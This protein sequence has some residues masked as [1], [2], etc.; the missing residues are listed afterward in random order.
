M[1]NFCKPL[2][3]SQPAPLSMGFSRQESW[4]GLAFSFPGESS[5]LKDQTY[6]SCVPY[7]ARGFFYPLSC[8][9]ASLLSPLALNFFCS[10]KETAVRNKGQHDS[11]IVHWWEYHIT[12]P[13]S[14]E[15]CMQ[16][17]KQQLKLDMDNRLV[18]SWERSTSRLYIVTLFF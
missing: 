10:N 14:W 9:E 18:P 3:C 5:S 2:D 7:F 6:V 16:V 17:R 4:N 11:F 15:I 8:Q 12:W 13:A 1:S